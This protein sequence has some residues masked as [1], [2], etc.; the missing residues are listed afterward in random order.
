MPSSTTTTVRPASGSRGRP[1]PVPRGA[2]DHLRLLARLHRGH[3]IRR[4]PHRLDDLAVDHLHPFSPTA[5]IPSSGWNGIPSLRNHDH[6]QRRAQRPGHLQRNRDTAPRQAEHD[7]RFA[8]QML[9]PGAQ[10]PPR[11]GT[12]GTR[13]PWSASVTFRAEPGTVITIAASTGGHV[14][15]VERFAVTGARTS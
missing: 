9:Q 2:G 10:P 6:I 8:P 4:Y 3:L 13:S 15:A 12:I 7:H 5:P 1:A 11:I 14:A